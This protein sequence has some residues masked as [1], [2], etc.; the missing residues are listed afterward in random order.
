MTAIAIDANVAV[1]LLN[2]GDPFHRLAISRCLNATEV[3]M[4]NITHAEALIH[5]TKAGKFAEAAAE[6]KL[7][8]VRVHV[9]DNRTTDTARQLRAEYGKRN[10]PM[11]DA[12]VVAFG[13]RR[14]V[15]VITCDAKWPTI[16]EAR[17]EVLQL[18]D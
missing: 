3:V 5:P 18:D 9:L 13:I 7:L 10:F 2:P 11:V 16:P 12:V 6:L 14:D 1:A 17:V 8:G 15:P 4:L